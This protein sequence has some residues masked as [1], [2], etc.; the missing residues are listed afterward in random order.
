MSEPTNTPPEP[1]DEPSLVSIV[2]PVH[3]E[4]DNVGPLVDGIRRAMGSG[5][6][7]VIFVD[8]GSTDHTAGAVAEL[9]EADERLCGLSLSRCFGH[10]DALGAGLRYAAGDAVIMMDGDLQH[11]PEILPALIGK[12]REGYNIVQARRTDT[13]DTTWLKRTSSW[14]FYRIFTFLSGVKLDPGMAD[15]RLLDR[16]VVE[17]INRLRGGRL[18]LRGL[19]AWMGYCRAEV[20]FDAP[21]RAAGESKYTLRRSLRLAK[22]GMLAFSAS[23]MRVGIR[24]GLIVSLLSF[25]YLLFVVA[26]K[27]LGWADV[28]GWASVAGM[29]SL[30]GG[31]LLL[32]MGLQGEYLI[33]I[34]E[35]VEQRPA[36]LVERVIGRP[37]KLQRP[38]DADERDDD[39][40]PNEPPALRI[41]T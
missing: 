29:I 21:A 17:E 25:A 1:R 12:W 36:F 31:V 14:T 16:Q 40:G 41:F 19:I 4:A 20:R 15:F 9:A 8:D 5:E 35:R 24:V 13:T 37:K 30:V 2:V 7:E 28:S 23:P 18:F 27:V 38:P 39:A 22:D 6:Y 3:N 34:Y 11:P 32:L 33:R 26:A 10:Q